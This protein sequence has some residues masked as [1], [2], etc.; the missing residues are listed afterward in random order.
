[1]TAP[2][3]FIFDDNIGQ[4]GPMTDTRA[5]FSIATGATNN[6]TRIETRVGIM[7]MDLFCD[8]GVAAIWRDIETDAH[9]NRPL[10]RERAITFNVAD[11][12][13]RWRHQTVPGNAAVIAV[14]GRWSGLPLFLARRVRDLPLG[15]ALIQSDGQVIAVHL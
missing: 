12:D 2:R 7:A 6:R 13:G 14:N 1:M 9:I 10:R 15:K 4:F 3:L 5:A 8:E 11:T